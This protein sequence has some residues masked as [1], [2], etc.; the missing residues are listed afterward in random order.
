MLQVMDEY[1]N[2]QILE[3]G[4]VNITGFRI[5]Q[6][7]SLDFR[8]F[9]NAWKRLDVTQWPGAGTKQISVRNGRLKPSLNCYG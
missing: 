5:L 2:S 4:A 1:L 8:Y 6:S 9:M 3:F 7:N